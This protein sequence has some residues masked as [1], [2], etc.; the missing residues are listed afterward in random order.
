MGLRRHSKASWS[1]SRYAGTRTWD[2][3]V[4]HPPCPWS[5]LSLAQQACDRPL[6]W[7]AQSLGPAA[8]AGCRMSNWE[9]SLI[10]LVS[11]GI[12]TFRE[13]DGATITQRI[14]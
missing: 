11:I 7:S 14:D 3:L 6:E 13:Q 2:F 8:A 4:V 12:W 5:R 1:L 10:V 9:G